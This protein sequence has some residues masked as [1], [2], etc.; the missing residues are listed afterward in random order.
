MRLAAA[1]WTLAALGLL[2]AVVRPALADAPVRLTVAVVKSR[3]LGPYDEAT[4][5]FTAAL[6]AAGFAPLLVPYDLGGDA[7]GA[8]GIVSTLRTAPPDL[9]LTLGS[10][11]TTEIARGVDQ[12]PI[13]F[14]MVLDPASSGLTAEGERSGRNL[15]GVSM[16][17][18]PEAQLD[19][20][21]RVLPGATRV[22]ILHG[23]ETETAVARARA[24]APSRGLTIVATEVASEREVAR[25]MTAMLTK[26]DVLLA[27]PDA[28]V[29]TES[30]TRYIL[31]QTLRQAQ[32]FMGLMESFVS[33]GALMGLGLD[34]ADL[35]AQAGGMAA[36]IARGAP[37]GSVAVQGPRQTR[38]LLNLRTARRIGVTIPDAVM[39]D[40]EVVVP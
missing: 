12:S 36:Q 31:L 2:L 17:I 20:I 7:G 38:L 29:Y 15:T 23:P 26:A 30:S 11:A 22:G 8:G 4:A 34:F 3:S 13:V 28:A 33:A 18:P 32:P 16:D 39:G 21:H 27:V 19:A 35:G 6:E 37:P 40:A 5:G 24:A 25:A 9:I 1:R 10:L 14:C